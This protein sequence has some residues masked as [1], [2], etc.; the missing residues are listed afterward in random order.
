MIA[1]DP[2]RHGSSDSG[3]RSRPSA[4][5]TQRWAQALLLGVLACGLVS[6]QSLSPITPTPEIK[7]NLQPEFLLNHLINRQTGIHTVRSFLKTAITRR[8][9]RRSFKQ[10]LLASDDASMRLDT[11]GMFNQVLGVLI[12]R[13]GKTSL[14]DAKNDRS[15][16][17]LE[18]LEVMEKIVGSRLDMNEF[19]SVLLSRAPRLE[20]LKAEQ[21][22][23]N[24][25][26]THYQL[27]SYDSAREETVEIT[28]DAAT[29][30][31]V[32]LVRHRKD[33]VVYELRWDN[34]KKI[35]NQYFP[36]SIT[37]ARPYLKETVSLDYDDPILN[38]EIEEE[39]FNPPAGA[40]PPPL[41]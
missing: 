28:I 33:F 7:E 11:L 34:Y 39:F 8:G 38:G 18:A 41:S 21:A 23:L 40:T 26:Q 4:G 31:P 15:Y 3:L 27:T 30:L 36:Q 32:R 9:E 2:C 25:D 37:L 19:S 13:N 12:H 6:C 24:E 14:F 22:S 35:N 16:V 29:L 5:K 20:S 10:A 17:D 1:P